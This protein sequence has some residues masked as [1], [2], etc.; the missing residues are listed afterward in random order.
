MTIAHLYYDLL[1]LYGESGN[2][3]TLKK[4][5]ESLGIK[6]N[7]LN[8]SIG[9]E[10]CFSDYDIVY[11]GMGT[12][13]NQKMVINHLN[14]YKEDIL[15]SIN[16]G[17]YF[18]LTGNSLDL[19]GKKINGISS[20]GIFNYEVVYSECRLV[21]EAIYSCDLIKDKI[22]GLVNKQSILLNYEFG[23]LNKLKV[24]ESNVGDVL[25]FNY[26]NLYATDLIG[27]LFIKNPLLLKYIIKKVI[28][29]NNLKVKNKLDLSFD[30][31]AYK[32]YL[33]IHG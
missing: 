8:L 31:K 22:I 3:L 14:D 4:N 21:E 5:I 18:I 11:I 17:K 29:D 7:L 12:E 24:I 27:P 1:N 6:V 9:D 16:L 20:L 2:V 32:K 26:K 10:L 15:E 25:F 33:K 30:L 19:F 13:N 28:K 23:V